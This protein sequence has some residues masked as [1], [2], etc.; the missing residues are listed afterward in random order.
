MICLL[1]R[2]ENV[3][4]QA[5]DGRTTLHFVTIEGHHEELAGLLLEHGADVTDEAKDWKPPLHILARSGHG[6]RGRLLLEHGAGP[7]LPATCG[8]DVLQH[9]EERGHIEFS[10]LLERRG[11]GA[12]SS[13][14]QR[15]D[16]NTGRGR[17]EICG[18]CMPTRVWARYHSLDG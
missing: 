15:T 1:E 16:S 8:H 13:G 4:A 9:A 11:D 17:Q 7:K 12:N 3:T 2:G 6:E 18:T 5:C 10:R 14:R